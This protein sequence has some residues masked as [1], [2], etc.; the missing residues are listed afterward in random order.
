MVKAVISNYIKIKGESFA[1]KQKSMSF[2]YCPTLG[3]VVVADSKSIVS[4]LNEQF[5]NGVDVRGNDLARTIVWLNLTTTAEND[6]VP[7]L[8]V[9]SGGE[10]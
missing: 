8:R 2:F 1:P 7:V 3:A 9:H 10:N 4:E 6:I 5:K